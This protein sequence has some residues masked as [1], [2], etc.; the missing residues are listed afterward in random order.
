LQRIGQD[1]LR[2]HL[3][4]FRGWPA[5]LNLE[6]FFNLI[7]EKQSYYFSHD[8]NARNDVKVIKLRRQLGLEGYG[9]YWCLI[10]MLRDA[11]ENR[12]PIDAIDDI[13][14]SLNINKE[15]IETVISNYGLFSVD[16]LNF[17]SQRLIRSME[18]YKEIKTKLSEG[19][20]KGMIARYKKD[21]PTKPEVVL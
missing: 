3:N 11:P 1:S 16:Q 17:F 2:T 7:M 8:S 6:R 19:G 18:Q 14:F 20:K 4:L 15:K 5:R 9:L 13:A 12:L 10:E 21:K